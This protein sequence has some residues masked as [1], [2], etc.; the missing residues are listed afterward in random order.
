MFDWIIEKLQNIAIWL[1]GF[2]AAVG[3]GWWYNPE[4]SQYLGK[5][6]PQSTALP[7]AVSGMEVSEV[8]RL[9]KVA[10]PAVKDAAGWAADILAVLK[11]HRLPQVRENVCSVIAVAD[12]ESGFVANPAIPNLGKMSEKAVNDKLHKL[13][14]LGDGA[15]LFLNQFPNKQN[16]FMQRIR[17][18]RT[19]RDLDLAYRDLIAGLE[20]YIRQYKLGLLVDNG[21]ARDLIEGSNEIDTIGSM[22]VAV[23]FAVQHEME[24]RGGKALTLED[25]YK[26][27]DNMYTRQGGL[28]YGT[29]LLLGYDTGYDKKLYRF[30]DFNAGRYSS[31]NAAFQ[32]V[33]GSLLGKKIATDG[34]LLIYKADGDVSLSVSGTE[35][36]VRDIVK[37]LA[38]DLNEFRIR[39]D[40]MQEKKLAFNDTPTYKAIM[41][42]YASAKKVKPTYAIVPQIQLHSEKTSR[43]LTTEKFA[44]T[45]YARYQKCVAQP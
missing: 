14:L 34:D 19:E 37:K 5:K 38:L 10:E 42:A 15:I 22:Q 21:I 44:N 36:A 12:Q 30:A 18:A 28:Y 13:S 17:N 27:R 11:L 31:R 26:V 1:V 23:D 40:L 24:K 39:R 9:I 43:I 6:Q 29:L 7:A 4:I 3:L 16:S 41:T 20:Q 45:V 32:S 25:I 33:V 35:Q 2:G 8:S